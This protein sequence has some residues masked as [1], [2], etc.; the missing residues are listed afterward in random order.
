MRL[1]KS[2]YFL[3]LTDNSS[4]YESG[5]GI[6]MN[7]YMTLEILA[8]TPGGAK[9]LVVYGNDYSLESVRVATEIAQF[10]RHHQKDETIDN[11]NSGVLPG[12]GR[13]GTFCAGDSTNLYFVP[14]NSFDAVFS[15]YLTPLPDPLSLNV[16][17][18][19]N[20]E[21]RYVELCESNDTDSI[22]LS[23][24]AQREQEKWYAAWVEEMIRIA[25]PGGIIMVEH[26]ALPLW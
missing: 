22:K 4:I 6:G 23:A 12:G 3:N 19:S 16:T 5:F 26:V 25:K 13:L 7:L 20:T 2:K 10:R 1:W 18:A 11:S 8:E 17:G 24:R 15:G 14:S 21:T 9:N